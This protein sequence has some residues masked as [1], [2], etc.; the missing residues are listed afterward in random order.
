MKLKLTII[1]LLVSIYINGQNDSIVLYNKGISNYK[2]GNYEEAIENYTKLM[3]IIEETSIQKTCY[4]NRG[5][6]YNRL[7]KYDLAIADFTNAIKLD[8]TDMASFID[9]GLSRMYSGNYKEAKEDY[10]YVV[11]TKSNEGMM[12]S[13]LYWLARIHYSERKFDE[14]IKNCDQYLKINPRDPELYF[15]R[16]VSND[17]QGNYEQSIKDYNEATK[18]KP[19]YVQAIA[20]RGTAKINLLTGRGNLQPSRSE[21]RHAC[22]DLKK[23]KK[24]GDN[25]VED[26]IYSYCGSKKGEK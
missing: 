17:M 1:F 19:N 3:T 14:V 5:L 23:A 9:R 10:T 12:E 4:I 11:D 18:L 8:S 7:G 21:T 20:N 2:S 26:L 6:S 13:A 22:R 15:I 16:G 25:S 24:L